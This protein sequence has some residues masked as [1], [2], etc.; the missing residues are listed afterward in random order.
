MSS[1]RTTEDDTPIDDTNPPLTLPAIQ[2]R[3]RQLL[4]RLPSKADTAAL[5]P[6]NVESLERWCRQVRSTL[7]S[8]NL[9]LN[10]LSVATY[11]LAALNN[12]MQ[13]GTARINILQN[14]I[15]RVLTPALTRQLT[16]KRL[17]V[18]KSKPSP[19]DTTTSADGNVEEIIKE[20]FYEYEQVV[21]DPEMLQ[22]NREQMCDEAIYKRQLVVSVM[23]QM[24]QCIDDYMKAE[25]GAAGG[26]AQRYSMAY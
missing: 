2:T 13:S 1:K 6:N 5:S 23:E 20:E 7:R 9:V 10:F 11:H 18:H 25:A 19:Q 15:S 8:Y 22:L 26:D 24:C 16:K 4:D 14:D 12:Q 3:I 17:V 21:N